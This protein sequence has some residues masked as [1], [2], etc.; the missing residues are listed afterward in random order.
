MFCTPDVSCI[1]HTFVF[2]C[3]SNVKQVTILQNSSSLQVSSYASNM[4]AMVKQCQQGTSPCKALLWH[5]MSACRPKA[6][7]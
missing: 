4:Q 3:C 6:M 5:V 1:I 7:A 2:S